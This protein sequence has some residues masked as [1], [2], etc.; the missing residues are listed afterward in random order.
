MAFL[1]LTPFVLYFLFTALVWWLFSE[2]D[3]IK[4]LRGY[5]YVT[6][7]VVP[8][9]MFYLVPIRFMQYLKCKV[10]GEDFWETDE[11][12]KPSD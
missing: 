6:F 4:G 1:L 7:L 11:K 10:T 9:L 2:Y 8:F 12:S 3:P 5:V